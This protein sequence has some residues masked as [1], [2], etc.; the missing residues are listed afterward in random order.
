MTARS[1]DT[2]PDPKPEDRY[3]DFSIN[4]P[5]FFNFGYDI[6]DAW[7][8]KEPDKTAMLWVSQQGEERRYSFRDMKLGSDLAAQILDDVG[9]SKGARVF[10]MLPRIPEW[11]ILVVALIKLGAVYLE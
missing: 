11:W 8:A 9:I 10:I 7:A 3:R 2:S 6:V 5:E 4:L 1:P